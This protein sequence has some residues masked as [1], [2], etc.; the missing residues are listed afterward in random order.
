MR[1]RPSL[2]CAGDLAYREANKVSVFWDGLIEYQAR[3]LDQYRC[4]L[5]ALRNVAGNRRRNA[6][7]NYLSSDE[8]RAV[9]HG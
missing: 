6:N 9:R 5:V 2:D 1:K 7:A 3:P 8:R 4:R